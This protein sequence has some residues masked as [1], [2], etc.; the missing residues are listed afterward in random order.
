MPQKSVRKSAEERINCHN[1][2]CAL[3][4]GVPILYFASAIAYFHAGAIT[5]VNCHY[6]LRTRHLSDWIR[7]AADMPYELLVEEYFYTLN[8]SGSLKG[9]VPVSTVQ[10][11]ER[12]GSHYRAFYL[13]LH[14][15]RKYQAVFCLQRFLGQV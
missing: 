11:H 12:I 14:L 2:N 8:L 4:S 10:V 1:G 9:L 7:K 3:L 13:G 15:S 5:S 6:L